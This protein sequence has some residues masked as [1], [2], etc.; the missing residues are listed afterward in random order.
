MSYLRP[1]K[2]PICGSFLRMR[3]DNGAVEMN[4]SN[5]HSRRSA[6]PAVNEGKPGAKGSNYDG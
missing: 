5:S 6:R 1:R 4:C 2:C 3:I